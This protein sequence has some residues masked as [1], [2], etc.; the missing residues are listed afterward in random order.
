[1][2]KSASRILPG[3]VATML[4][5]PGVSKADGIAS[6]NWEESGQASWYGKGFNGRRTSSGE[7]FNQNH[8][9]AAHAFLPLGS[10]IRVTMQETGDSVV[11]T[12]TDRQP[13]RGYR[14]I[15]LSRGAASRLG[16]LASG[17]AMVTLTAAKTD[18]VEV[19]EAADDG[20]DAFD[21]IP[22][23][24]GRPHTRRAGLR[25]SADRPCCRAPSVVLARHSAPPRAAR[26]RL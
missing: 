2:M 23:P 17:T 21:A 26:R 5:M 10:K 9:T 24:R 22:Q 16:M 13:P 11:V 7:I 14:V 8:M 1:M 12:I 15:D 6:P 20:A 4:L 18:D 19:A 25:A 3:V